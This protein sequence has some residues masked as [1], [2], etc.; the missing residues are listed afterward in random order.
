[1]Y[2]AGLDEII[3]T[4]YQ[5]NPLAVPAGADDLIDLVEP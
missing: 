4:A 1:V 2:S 5:A 3:Q